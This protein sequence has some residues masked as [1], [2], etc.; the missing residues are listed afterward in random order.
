MRESFRGMCL[1][2]AVVAGALS[3]VGAGPAARV[4]PARLVNAGAT[5][6]SSSCPS[7]DAACFTISEDK[8]ATSTWC[9]SKLGKCTEGLEGPQRWSAHAYYCPASGSCMQTF[10]IKATWDPRR[11]NPSSETI[12]TRLK[13]PTDGY[14]Y[15]VDFLACPVHP[16]PSDPGCIEGDEGVEIVRP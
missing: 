2:A 13:K 14:T 15:Q 8:P 9:I 4:V 16:T 6:A 3:L 11:G 1:G 5:T 7:N 10:K 12:S